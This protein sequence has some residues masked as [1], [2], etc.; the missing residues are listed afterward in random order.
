MAAATPEPPRCG[1][2]RDDQAVLAA[3]VAAPGPVAGA[4][5]IGSSTELTGGDDRR[6][7]APAGC[8]TAAAVPGP[9]PGRAN[10]C[11]LHRRS[12]AAGPAHGARFSARPSGQ[13]DRLLGSSGPL[14]HTVGACIC[15]KI[16]AS[17]TEVAFLTLV[18]A[19]TCLVVRRVN[20]AVLVVVSLAVSVVLT[21]LVLKPIFDRTLHGSL[22]YPSGHAGRA[23]TLAAV[24]VVLLLD[25][26]GRRLEPTAQDRYRGRG[27]A[28]ELRGSGR[29]DRAELPLFHRHRRRCGP[30]DRRCAH[31]VTAPGHRARTETA[32]RNRPAP[33]R[34]VKHRGNAA[35]PNRQC[36]ADYSETH[37]RRLAPLLVSVPPHLGD[38]SAGPAVR[39]A[40]IH[41]APALAAI[42][43][44]VEENPPA[45]RARL[46]P[47]PRARVDGG[48]N[49]GE[50]V[51][52][53][54]AGMPVP[55]LAFGHC[56]AHRKPVDPFVEASCLGRATRLDQPPEVIAK[57]PGRC[58]LTLGPP[59]GGART[60]RTCRRV[61]A[62]RWE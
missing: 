5:R 30:G 12:P 51:P 56:G 32:A 54:A 24:V 10:R 57:F 61:A 19:L 41:Q 29:N 25:P 13:R 60:R 31:R 27:A 9:P 2:V 4:P 28:H 42:T 50:M 33:S 21:E 40:R 38:R 22:V 18:I 35:E 20:G 62:S 37:T 58:G 1:Q 45:V 11:L 16:S 36:S 14:V 8:S 46:E 49:R 59:F 6:R 26:P 23:F 15:S 47:L 7:A 17:R 43:S 52:G 3:A 34:S 48:E 39:T 53:W 44:V 55:H